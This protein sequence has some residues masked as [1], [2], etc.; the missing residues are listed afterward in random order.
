MITSLIQ[1]SFHLNYCKNSLANNDYVMINY[2]YSKKIKNVYLLT[3]IK[4]L[5]QKYLAIH[6]INQL[7]E[8]NNILDLD[9]DLIHPFFS[10]VKIYKS[11]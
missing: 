2:F 6:D 3:L 1:K 10:N 9:E 4:I 11:K 8:I 7:I 5:I